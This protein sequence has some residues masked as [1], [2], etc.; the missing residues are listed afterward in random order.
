M[1]TL[2]TPKILGK[3]FNREE[4]KGGNN[5]RKSGISQNLQGYFNRGFKFS[6]VSL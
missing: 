6:R 4:L 3:V 1:I 2:F 5:L